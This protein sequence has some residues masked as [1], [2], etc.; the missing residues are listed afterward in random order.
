MEEEEEGTVLQMR[1]RRNMYKIL[2]GR[3]L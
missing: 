1:K 2:V 3:A